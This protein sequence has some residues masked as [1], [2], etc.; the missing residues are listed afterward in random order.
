MPSEIHQCAVSG[1]NNQCAWNKITGMRKTLIPAVKR[2]G[3]SNR[4]RSVQIA[5]ATRRQAIRPAQL[6]SAAIKQAATKCK[7][8]VRTGM[9][10]NYQFSYK[11]T[12][13]SDVWCKSGEI[14][15]FPHELPSSLTR[16][17]QNSRGAWPFT[18]GA[19]FLAALPEANGDVPASPRCPARQPERLISRSATTARHTQPQRFGRRPEKPVTSLKKQVFSVSSTFSSG[20]ATGLA[21]GWFSREATT[22][23]VKFAMRLALRIGQSVK[24]PT[25]LSLIKRTL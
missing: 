15:G 22:E 14:L 21:T 23:A 2:T 19:T 9:G 5:P 11:I 17:Q 6:A 7:K 10:G 1:D 3:Q 8:A 12:T 13:L 18:F 4:A 25:K 24:A 20:F 16:F